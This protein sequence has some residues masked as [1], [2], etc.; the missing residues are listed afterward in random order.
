MEDSRSALSTHQQTTFEWVKPKWS[1]LQFELRA[2]NTVVATL[3]W[4]RGRQ[5]LGRW[6]GTS[7]RFSQKGWLRPRVLIWSAAAPDADAP[8]ATF[9]VHSGTLTLSNGRAAYWRK[10]RRLT[11]EHI[12]VNDTGVELARFSPER[13]RT[14]VST[15]LVPDQDPDLVLLILL[16][17][18]LMVSA[19]Q[20]AEAATTAAVVASVC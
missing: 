1:R 14:V 9:E 16:G 5:A 17:Q 13:R 2:G 7:Y 10:P 11:R 4:S 12:W 19:A 18:Y 8:L 20:D 6:G 15:L 3:E